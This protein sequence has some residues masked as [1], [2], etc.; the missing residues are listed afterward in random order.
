MTFRATIVRDLIGLKPVKKNIGIEVEMEGNKP[1]PLTI[2][3]KWV[4]VE[5]HSL[6][7]YSMEYVTIGAIDYDEVGEYLAA[8]STTLKDNNITVKHSFRAGVHVHIN[9]QELNVDQILSYASTYY[10]METALT[11]FCGTNREGNFF[12]LRA[13]DAEYP[14]SVL[15]AAAK[16]RDLHYLNTDDLRYAALNL[17]SLFRHGTLEFRAMETHPDLSK[18]EPWAKMLYRMREYSK[19]LLRKSAI[20]Y[21]ISYFGPRHWVGKV[22]GQEFL[23]LIDYPDLEKDVIKDMRLVQELLYLENLYE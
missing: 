9:C 13:Q 20:P 1:F 22:L 23:N 8:L 5:D 19:S 10:C 21:D 3:N 2:S 4:G 11:R 12:C 15:L 17:R 7:G 6:R 18:I 16:N 14:I